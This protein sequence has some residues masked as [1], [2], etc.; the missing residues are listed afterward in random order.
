VLGED[1]RVKPGHVVTDLNPMSPEGAGEKARRSLLDRE[2]RAQ[3]VLDDA[4]EH[5]EYVAR[6]TTKYLEMRLR[7]DPKLFKSEADVIAFI[8]TKL[9]DEIIKALRKI[10]WGTTRAPSGGS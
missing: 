3:S 1:P 7:A 5:I 6:A 10:M 9:K 2:G 4:D 8:K